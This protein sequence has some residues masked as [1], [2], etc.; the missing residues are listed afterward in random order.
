MEQFRI[1]RFQKMKAL[2]FKSILSERIRWFEK[3]VRAILEVIEILK[4][5]PDSDDL[6]PNYEVS[7]DLLKME[8]N[9][10]N[11]GMKGLL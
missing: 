11:F 6:N 9:L 2:V 3:Q 5:K 4:L 1:D 8:K 7:R 10:L